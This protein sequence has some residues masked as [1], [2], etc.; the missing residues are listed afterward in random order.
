MKYTYSND[1]IL[2]NTTKFPLFFT[3]IVNLKITLFV[4]CF[5]NVFQPI[6]NSVSI[7]YFKPGI[8]YVLGAISSYGLSV[9]K[10]TFTKICHNKFH[11]SHSRYS[12]INQRCSSRL[13]ERA[14]V[15]SC[16]KSKESLW[17]VHPN[18]CKTQKAKVLDVCNS[19]TRRPVLGNVTTLFLT[20]VMFNSL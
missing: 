9:S 1:G 6:K 12:H 17:R 2:K 3:I 7:Q 5:G 20:K 14:F 16:F 4:H 8:R 19:M 11:C 15:D 18:H 13:P 10:N